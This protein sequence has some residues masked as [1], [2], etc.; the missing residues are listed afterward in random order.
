MD[1]LEALEGQETLEALEG[2]EALDVL[3]T[4]HSL[5]LRENTKTQAGC[6]NAFSCRR[7]QNKNCHL[8]TFSFFSWLPFDKSS[9]QV[10]IL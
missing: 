6:K 3:E 5:E 4:L 1:E 8:I 2:Q 10:A 9:Q 7:K